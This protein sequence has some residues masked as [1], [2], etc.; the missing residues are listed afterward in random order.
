MKIFVA[1]PINRPIEF[2]SF[3]C[4]VRLAN[5]RGKH[6][7]HFGFTQNSLVYDARESLVES[8]LKTDCEA[9]MF[10]DSDMTFD[11]RSAEILESHNL[12]IVS[13]RAFKRVPPYE[14]CFYTKF[15]I[16]DGQPYLES[17]IGYEQGLLPVDGFGMACCLIRREVFE[18]VKPP[19]FFPQPMIGEDLSFCLRLK[20]AGIPLYVDTTLQFGHLAQIPIFEEHFHKAWLEQQKKSENSMNGG[21]EK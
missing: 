1:V 19:Y 2:L 13:A 10:I 3:E 17:P 18:K 5:F 16:R 15:E 21:T 20:E 9:L 8:F 11:W 14:P 12:P 4:F 7:Y 6:E